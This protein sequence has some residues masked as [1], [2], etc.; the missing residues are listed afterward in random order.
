MKLYEFELTKSQSIEKQLMINITNLK[1]TETRKDFKK[2]QNFIS[3]LP[4]KKNFS[5][6][7]KIPRSYESLAKVCQF[8]IDT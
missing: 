5:A 7:L 6:F 4:Q 2:A 3:V 1:D 8:A